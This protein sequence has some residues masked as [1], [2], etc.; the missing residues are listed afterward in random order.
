MF[1]ILLKWDKLVLK[2]S[3]GGVPGGVAG[4]ILVYLAPFGVFIG[5]V[6]ELNSKSKVHLAFHYFGVLLMSLGPFPIALQ[7]K[8]S[9]LSVLLIA[10]YFGS[11]VLWVTFSNVLPRTSNNP[12]I[13]HITSLYCLVT[14]VAA[15]IFVTI[16]VIW[17]IYRLGSV[18]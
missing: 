16:A 5:A 17:Y 8:W 6:W 4:G 10:G 18:Y 12:E 2:E 14:E 15:T 3:E 13:V 11:I 7:T 1:A 9:L